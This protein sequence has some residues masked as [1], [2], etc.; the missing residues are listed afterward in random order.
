MSD[1]VYIGTCKNLKYNNSKLKTKH[2]GQHY[3]D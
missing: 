3:D 1:I 2:Y